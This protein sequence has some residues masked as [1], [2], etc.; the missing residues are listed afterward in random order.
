MTPGGET[1][2]LIEEYVAQTATSAALC[3]TPLD[4]YRHV[5]RTMAGSYVSGRPV[6][7]TVA[8]YD[9]E[10]E[11]TTEAD[12][13]P[14]VESVL[15]QDIDRFLA[16]QHAADPMESRQVAEDAAETII[17]SGTVQASIQERPASDREEVPE[18]NLSYHYVPAG[19]G[20]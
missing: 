2:E 5:G 13:G 17:G 18:Y 20:S 8:F 1:E 9:P 7:G 11:V 12:E 10:N 19:D 14:A 6:Q 3:D 15:A 16:E 4:A